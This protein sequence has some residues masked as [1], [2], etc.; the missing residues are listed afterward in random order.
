[1]SDDRNEC[2]PAESDHAILSG[3]AC[4]NLRVWLFATAVLS[5]RDADDQTIPQSG[6]NRAR[7]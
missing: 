6:H 7:G 4:S 2:G 1:M 5:A 3:A